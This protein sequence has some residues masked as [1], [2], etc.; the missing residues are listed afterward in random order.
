MIKECQIKNFK[1]LK[2]CNL[3]AFNR[4]TLLGGKN[5]T[6]K[7][8]LMEA[9]FLSMD[10]LNP[11]CFMRLHAWRGIQGLK[12]DG[13]EL[14]GPLFYDYD[15]S[16]K[17]EII[18]THKNGI[19]E[20]LKI[21][22]EKQDTKKISLKEIDFQNLN[23]ETKILKNENRLK[24]I[25]K[26]SGKSS[27]KQEEVIHSIE[28]NDLNVQLK[29]TRPQ[30]IKEAIFLIAKQLL[31][32]NGNSLRYSQLVKNNEE[33]EILTFLKVIEPR[34]ISLSTVQLN[35]NLTAIYGDIGL[36]KKVPLSYMGDGITRVLSIL[37]SIIVN[38]DGVVFVDEIENGI[39]HS[40]M[41][42]VWKIIDEASQKNNCQVIATTHSYECLASFTSATKNSSNDVSYIRLEREN[43]KVLSKEYDYSMLE[44]AMEQGWEVR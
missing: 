7:T 42:D 13:T 6:G 12:V 14:F 29:D 36:K 5:N 20:D 26:F 2:E 39:H 28:G 37:L 25:T 30:D 22:L 34:L 44:V 21:E 15:I 1:S 17:I 31:G 27:R 35:D 4:I 23:S 19:K 41:E 10:R 40:I 38:K 24:M 8:A 11:E 3:K 18:I 16:Q 43:N 33:K 32:D 9:I